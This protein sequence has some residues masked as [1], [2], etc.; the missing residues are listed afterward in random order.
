MDAIIK[1]YIVVT[2]VTY[3]AHGNNQTDVDTVTACSK[4]WY[5]KHFVNESEGMTTTF[6]DQYKKM[7]EKTTTKRRI[8]NSGEAFITYAE[9]KETSEFWWIFEVMHLNHSDDCWGV[10]TDIRSA[11][12]N[13]HNLKYS[14]FDGKYVTKVVMHTKAVKNTNYVFS[15]YSIPYGDKLQI[16]VTTPGDCE[17][18]VLEIIYQLLQEIDMD[19]KAQCKNYQMGFNSR[20]DL[21]SLVCKLYP[22]SKKDRKD[23]VLN[24]VRTR[25]NTLK[26][27]CEFYIKT[28]SPSQS[29]K[30]T[31]LTPVNIVLATISITLVATVCF[32][33]YF[34]NRCRGGDRQTN[35]SMDPQGTVHLN[36]VQRVNYSM[37]YGTEDYVMIDQEN[38]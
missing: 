18:E 1:L 30:I 38:N 20:N 4:N 27:F 26:G 29:Q 3:G 5:Y 23:L 17:N 21:A 2:L 19:P 8:C 12:G 24:K 37:R 22:N 34:Y 28:D 6:F 33:V 36:R 25:N 14:N 13:I 9:S 7:C 10:Y 35:S 32:L 31:H 15:S 11:N 16:S